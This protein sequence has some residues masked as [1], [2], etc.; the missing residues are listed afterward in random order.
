M[1]YRVFLRFR[2][3]LRLPLKT[4][5]GTSPPIASAGCVTVFVSSC[6]A[7]LLCARLHPFSCLPGHG[8]RR[9][10]VDASGGHA[11]AYTLY[12]LPRGVHTSKSSKRSRSCNRRP[13]SEQARPFRTAATAGRKSAVASTSAWGELLTIRPAKPRGK[14]GC[15]SAKICRAVLR[16]PRDGL[17]DLSS[18]LVT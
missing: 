2:G 14:N 6:G 18:P 5:G 15:G 10:P 7:V 16:P 13:V 17:H 12:R 4:E 8:E 1:F 3:V 11:N 9:P